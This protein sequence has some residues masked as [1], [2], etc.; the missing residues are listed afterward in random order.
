[1]HLRLLHTVVWLVTQSS[2]INCHAKEAGQT[3]LMLAVSHGR[4]ETARLLLE[5]GAEINSRDEDGSTA[6][7]CAAEHNHLEIV[8]L[9]LAHPS[10]DAT[11]ADTV[12]GTILICFHFIVILTLCKAIKIMKCYKCDQVIDAKVEVRTIFYARGVSEV[13]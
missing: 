3:A 12:I 5:C 10:C 4:L 1:M 2:D 13:K 7:M 9:L 8:K 11:L 6:L